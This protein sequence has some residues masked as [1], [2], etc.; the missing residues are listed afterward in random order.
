VGQMHVESQSTPNNRME[1]LIGNTILVNSFNEDESRIEAGHELYVTYTHVFDFHLRQH[2]H[3][4]QGFTSMYIGGYAMSFDLTSQRTDVYSWLPSEFWVHKNQTDAYLWGPSDEDEEEGEETVGPFF[5]APGVDPFA[6]T[7]PNSNWSNYI[8]DK[9][10]I[11]QA[12]EEGIPSSQV[13]TQLTKWFG[14]RQIN[15][16]RADM[17]SIVH[18]PNGLIVG[19]YS[20]NGG[21]PG[22]ILWLDPYYNVR[23]LIPRDQI[24]DQEWWN[25]WFVEKVQ[26]VRIGGL[27]INIGAFTEWDRHNWD[28]FFDQNIFVNSFLTDN[29]K[30]AYESFT[31]EAFNNC[32]EFD[33]N[34]DTE[35]TGIGFANLD[36]YE[37]GT[38]TPRVDGQPSMDSEYYSDASSS[39]FLTP[40]R[41]S[42][43]AGVWEPIMIDTIPGNFGSPASVTQQATYMYFQPLSLDLNGRVFFEVHPPVLINQPFICRIVTRPTATNVTGTNVNFDR[44]KGLYCTP[45]SNGIHSRMFV[46]DSSVLNYIYSMNVI[47]SGFSHDD[48]EESVA[49]AN[50]YSFRG[51]VGDNIIYSKG[52]RILPKPTAEK[53]TYLSDVDVP[54][55]S[56]G[57]ELELPGYVER[58]TLYYDVKGS[59]LDQA[60]FTLSI[61]G[62]YAETEVIDIAGLS[63]AGYTEVYLGYTSGTLIITSNIDDFIVSMRASMFYIDEDEMER[64]TKECTS[65][66]PFID[67]VGNYNVI[68]LLSETSKTNMSL[69]RSGNATGPYF[70]FNYIFPSIGNDVL[71]NLFVRTDFKNNYAYVFF[72]LDGSLLM[73]RVSY[74]DLDVA[75]TLGV[76]EGFFEN[77]FDE[78]GFSYIGYLGSSYPV[79][80][81]NYLLD[82]FNQ[83]RQL[84]DLYF[85]P[86][87]LITS[88]VIDNA[89]LGDEMLSYA[90]SVALESGA[91]N[92]QDYD[93]TDLSDDDK[94]TSRIIVPSTV[95]D[96][97]LGN[98][99][100]YLESNGYSFPVDGGF[101]VEIISN[102]NLVMFYTHEG[103]VYGKISSGLNDWSPLFKI[104]DEV[105]GFKPVRVAKLYPEEVGLPASTNMD[106]ITIGDLDEEFL[107]ID[108]S[109]DSFDVSAISSC[110]EPKSD[111]LYLFYVLDGFLAFDKISG[112]SLV[113][114]LGK[115]VFY[116]LNSTTPR[117]ILKSNI[118]EYPSFLVGSFPDGFSDSISIEGNNYLQ[119]KYSIDSIDKF[120]SDDLSVQESPVSAFI[121]NNGIVRFM[122]ADSDGGLRGGILSGLRP[123][124]DVQLRTNV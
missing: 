46:T 39:F 91:A 6:P 52:I 108:L 82:K 2:A 117:S 105:F 102:G 87:Y 49:Y 115:S 51:L 80:S 32:S 28:V 106:D 84:A 13:E 85:E 120:Q 62:S 93:F 42:E 14:H 44:T 41:Q 34:D 58:I 19:S 54:K 38:L 15:S 40:P 89:W 12:A 71:S 97:Y 124:L 59:L 90:A 3:I 118:D 114:D 33:I 53:V 79:L 29:Q 45:D 123:E 9:E 95:F 92:I 1:D 11:K 109:F 21:N 86:S 88:N 67:E 69:L 78:A 96:A 111:F 121:L 36:F 17:S 8:E 76:D 103:R 104:N 101:T 75:Q 26:R 55:G 72:V 66:F 77:G 24:R 119:F 81:Y 116:K 30:L 74:A 113:E 35:S 5:Y 83:C 43:S 16:M 27:D 47:P 65:C 70:T 61:I 64:I 98:D 68:E 48:I 110:Y 50:L 94:Y 18:F 4:R 23:V 22:G 56:G 73:K 100:D 25:E 57:F 60:Y 10:L 20:Y 107:D 37:P 122:Y 63:S 99:S 7:L 31:A 112:M